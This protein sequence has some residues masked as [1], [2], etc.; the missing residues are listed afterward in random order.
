M[1]PVHQVKIFC[2]YAHQDQIFAHQLKIHFAALTR[3]YPCV[4][5]TDTEISAGEE[6]EQAIR[7][8]LDTAQIILLLVSPDFIASDYCY[9]KEMK[10]AMER[11]EQGE[12][13]VIPIIVRRVA[14]WKDAPFGKLQ[15]LPVVG[16]AVTD[17]YWHTSDDAFSHVVE[18]ISET[19]ARRAGENI[20]RTTSVISH[21]PP[22]LPAPDTPSVTGEVHQE[23]IKLVP[24]QTRSEQPYVKASP[25][26]EL[27]RQGFSFVLDGSVQIERSGVQIFEY[28]QE[29]YELLIR[30]IRRYGAREAVLIQYSCHSSLD[31]LRVLLRKGAK[32]TLFIQHEETATNLRSR[33]QAHRIIDTTMNLRS[34]LGDALLEPEQ[35]EVYK[36]RVASSM[37]A[38]KIDN[39]V[40]YMGWYTYE[41][42]T[43]PVHK[44]FPEDT[45]ELSG[46]DRAAV[47]AW[48][49]TNDP[50]KPG[51]PFG[52][53][54]D[55]SDYQ[56]LNKTFSKL[57][58]NYREH[59]EIV[60]I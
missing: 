39:R 32:V 8:H 35:L 3:L 60:S 1:E 11:H 15:A 43:H 56:K 10:R 38:V 42:T 26:P 21:T 20:M 27:Q 6:W 16:R 12:V 37:S 57:E 54:D 14:H 30:I 23:P 47:V 53:M 41:Q 22:S 49:G 28:Q 52:M 24:I 19:V 9:G 51:E 33:F 34:E 5:W 25:K 17:V 50:Q 40:L 7:R 4:F 29:A 44:A 13:C 55:M 48:E 31:L 58:E 36:Y 46:H 2:S 59:A 18:K 45:F